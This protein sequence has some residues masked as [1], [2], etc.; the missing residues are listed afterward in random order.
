MGNWANHNVIHNLFHFSCSLK[1]RLG[2]VCLLPIPHANGKVLQAQ[3]FPDR[4]C[5]M[6]FGY[7][8]W[9]ISVLYMA[10][11]GNCICSIDSSRL[12]LTN[13]CNLL[14][15]VKTRAIASILTMVINIFCAFVRAKHDESVLYDYHQHIE[16]HFLINWIHHFHHCQILSRWP[17]RKL[18]WCT[19]LAVPPADALPKTIME[20]QLW[21]KR[22][23]AQCRA[24]SSK[25]TF[26]APCGETMRQNGQN[27]YF[28]STPGCR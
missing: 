18:W 22:H 20:S 3:I 19:G 11:H 27:T 10:T 8:A 7:N 16:K 12:V 14:I 17:V 24:F 6:D 9:W 28:S 4:Y 5:S 2:C 21:F 26:F 25:P 13:A 1:L 15:S 23:H